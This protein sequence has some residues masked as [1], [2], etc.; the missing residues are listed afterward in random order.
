MIIDEFIEYLNSK[1]NDGV[2]VE[3][4]SKGEEYADITIFRENDGKWITLEVF[5]YESEE[6]EMDNDFSVF[7]DY[8]EEEIEIPKVKVKEFY[9]KYEDSNMDLDF[10]QFDN[11]NQIGRS[12]YGLDATEWWYDLRQYQLKEIPEL[13]LF[14]DVS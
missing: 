6:D 5:T 13:K 10:E 2:G 3:A 12:D 1:V 8:L 14:F 7:L 4:T 9:F 11:I